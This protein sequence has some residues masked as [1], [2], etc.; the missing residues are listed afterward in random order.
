M[1]YY[2]R[3]S[4]NLPAKLTRTEPHIGLRG[5][6]MGGGLTPS[7]ALLEGCILEP[8]GFRS[9][10]PPSGCPWG[11]LAPRPDGPP[12]SGGGIHSREGSQVA[13]HL[14][15]GVPSQMAPPNARGPLEVLVGHF[16]RFIWTFLGDI[17]VVVR[18]EFTVDY[19]FTHMFFFRKS[20]SGGITSSI[21]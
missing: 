9:P 17:L 15:P 5:G 10:W 21:V 8:T 6:A 16:H 11:P 1:Q 20:S 12:L 14:F 19:L 3:I 4:A 7:R 18:V 13:V 2:S